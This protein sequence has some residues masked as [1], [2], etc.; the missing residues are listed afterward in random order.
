MLE[1]SLVSL[2][3]LK[4][5]WDQKGKDYVDNF[6]PF[7]GEALRRSPQNQ[8]S[9]PQ[10]QTII[11]DDFGLVIPQGALNTLLH[12]AHRYGYVIRQRGIYERNL[13]EIPGT[14]IAQRESAARQQ[15][16]LTQKLV[17][18]CRTAYGVEWTEAQA[19]EALIRHLQR[20]GVAI[21]AASVNGLPIPQ[22]ADDVPNA[23]FLVSSFVLDLNHR[24]PDGFGFLETMM[25]GH[26]LA[27]ALFLPDISKANQKFNDL[28][29]FV[30]TRLLM[31]ALGFE[32]EGLRT[33]VVELLTLLY[34]MNVTL[35]CFDITVDEMRG[36]LDAAQNALRHTRGQQRPILFSVYEHFV[37]VGAKPSDIESIM[38]RLE[39]RLRVLHVRVKQTPKHT[40]ELGLDE[41]RLDEVIVEEIPNIRLEAKRH[42]VDCLTA[43]HRLRKGQRY[44]DIERS[45]Y[46]FL[47]S[48][49]SLARAA[50]KFFGEQYEWNTAPLCVSDHTLA[51]LAWV[52]NPSYVA[53]FS[54]HRLI[55]DSYAALSPS[56]EL[57][58]RYSDE[59]ARLREAGN[60]SD[61]EYQLLR[62]SIVAKKA[63]MDETLGSTEAFTEGTV[64]EVLERARANVRHEAEAELH[65]ERERRESAERETLNY[66]LQLE[67]RINRIRERAVRIGSI[68]GWIAYLV[69]AAIFT[70][71][72]YATLPSTLPQLVDPARHVIQA[73]ISLSA[74]LAI[75]SALEGGTVRALKRRV[76]VVAADIAERLLLWLA[77]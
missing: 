37:S 51:T 26:M 9:I 34:R 44:S 27:T 18:F 13:A 46:V 62:Y 49:Y 1:D 35:S 71:G 43:I 3:V 76:E 36:V 63:L 28:E 22:P 33:S 4:V 19:E 10:L 20:S 47:T 74:L 17:D 54:R 75:W 59:V 66:K 60:I 21:L 39:D 6:V 64:T 29:V 8:V 48:N 42:D 5:N 2:A 67:A 56:A 45:R 53:D 23:D 30:D 70:I 65:A 73:L 58:K 24:D 16:A 52:K 69:I 68:A 55:A 57:W 50:A 31:R 15:R 38:A 7:V 32:G 41:R 61:D 25:K 14:F 72:F 77:G 40:I 12:R 11:K